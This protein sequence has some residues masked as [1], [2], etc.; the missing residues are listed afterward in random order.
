MQ[1]AIRSSSA[2]AVTVGI[3]MLTHA[4]RLGHPIE[5]SIEGDVND[6]AK[7]KGPALFYSPVLSGCGVGKVKGSNALVCVPGPPC[8]PLLLSLEPGGIADWFSIDR[9]GSGVH[10]ASQDVVRLCRSPQA[11]AQNIG[12]VL[13]GAL[14]ALGCPAEPALLDVLFGAP[15]PPLV[16]VALSIRA[17][18]V[19]TG[20]SRDLLTQFIRSDPS[21]LPDALPTPLTPEGL[22]A[23]RTSGHLDQLLSRLKDG[24]QEAVEDWVNSLGGIPADSDLSTLLCAVAEVGSHVVSAPVTGMLRTLSSEQD[25]IATN[26]GR[27]LG[28]TRGGHCAMEAL[29]ETYRFLGGRFVEHAAYAVDIPGDPPPEG[30]SERWLWLCKSAFCAKDEAD[31]L[32]RRLI[33]PVQ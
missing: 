24:L 33:D 28:A 32:W 26:I 1:V 19:M 30:R 20:G 27:A 22:A 5:V 18:R 23:A 21:E 11:E 29:I 31:K 15:A 7:V 13:L 10:K 16:R 3:L 6:A 12:R 4:K 25:G 14:T 2:T 17:G 9:D 8:D